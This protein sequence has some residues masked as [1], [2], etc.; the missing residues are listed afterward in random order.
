MINYYYWNLNVFML[1]FGVNTLTERLKVNFI[2]YMG[3]SVKT[4][5]ILY[6]RSGIQ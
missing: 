1:T 4:G 5:S 6:V 3:F 2:L